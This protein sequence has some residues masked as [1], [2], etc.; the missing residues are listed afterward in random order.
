MKRQETAS[1]PTK[2][3]ALEHNVLGLHHEL[4]ERIQELK[5]AC[6]LARR[7]S[8]GSEIAA[9]LTQWEAGLEDLEHANNRAR[10]LAKAVLFDTGA[11]SV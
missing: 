4:R 10:N 8:G 5:G 2:Y 9:S 1:K 6:E 3:P 7:R 11:R